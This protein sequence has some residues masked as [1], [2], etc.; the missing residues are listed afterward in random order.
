MAIIIA[1]EVLYFKKYGFSFNFNLQLFLRELLLKIVVGLVNI[2]IPIVIALI[3]LLKTKGYIFLH[4]SGV[5]GHF[6]VFYKLLGQVN[7]ASLL[8][9]WTDLWCLIC[10]IYYIIE[11]SE[12]LISFDYKLSD[13]DE[14]LDGNMSA[15]M[16]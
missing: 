1:T 8:L 5:I 16:A 11:N 13:D 6:F 9:F 7:T 15:S 10:G 12:E 3:K 4:I 14:K 2:I